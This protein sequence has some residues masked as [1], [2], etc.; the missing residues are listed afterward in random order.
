MFFGF[1]LGHL[2]HYVLRVDVMT[3]DKLYGA[4]AAYMMLGLLWALCYGVVH[5]FYPG[6]YAVQ[7]APT[8]LDIAELVFFSFVVLTSTGFGDIVPLLM[9]SRFLAVLEALTGVMYVAILI[10]RLTGVYPVAAGRT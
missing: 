1:A 4:V 3:A 2:V 6:A 10:A 8:E 9:P 5:Y 7:G